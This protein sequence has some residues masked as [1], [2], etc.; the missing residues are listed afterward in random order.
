MYILKR[1][2]G[3]VGV[4]GA[5]GGGGGGGQT[6]RGGYHLPQ[7]HPARVWIMIHSDDSDD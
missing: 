5:V 1:D 3:G 4:E 6:D 7:T 2:R